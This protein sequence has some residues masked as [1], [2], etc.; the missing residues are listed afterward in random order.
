[1]PYQQ[2]RSDD[3]F[4]RSLF[5]PKAN[6]Q[7]DVAPL[8]GESYEQ[9]LARMQSPYKKPSGWQRFM[10]PKAS[11]AAEATNAAFQQAKMMGLAG[12]LE[13]RGLENERAKKAM[14]L[15]K[16]NREAMADLERQ[17]DTNDTYRAIIEQNNKTRAAQDQHQMALDKAVWDHL[18]SQGVNPSDPNFKN[19]FYSLK[20]KQM[21]NQYGAEK[22]LTPQDYFVREKAKTG[23][24]MTKAYLKSGDNYFA[25]YEQTP[26]PTAIMGEIGGVRK[27][28]DP[29]TMETTEKYVKDREASFGDFDQYGRLRY[30]GPNKTPKMQGLSG[31]TRNNL[32]GTS[33]ASSVPG[34]GTDIR[35]FEANPEQYQTLGDVIPSRPVSSPTRNFSSQ[36]Q[37]QGGLPELPQPLP[38]VRTPLMTEPL[39]TQAYKRSTGYGV[40]DNGRT[41]IDVIRNLFTPK[42]QPY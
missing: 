40:P 6:V 21:E 26:G 35:A 2:Y 24:A 23:E 38:G 9:Y 37:D 36:I 42:Q 7:A 28:V 30:I 8:A 32:Q 31:V 19:L 25:P 34:V 11:Q 3:G 16:Y 29:V 39:A 17:K 13:A 10:A 4:F 14:D 22:M 1:M 12:A 18:V 20:Q 27:V 15:A 5:A 33:F 41:I